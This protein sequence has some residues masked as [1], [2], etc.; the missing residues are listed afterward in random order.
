MGYIIYFYY[1][2]EDGFKH[3]FKQASWKHTFLFTY[4]TKMAAS[5]LAI[6][7]SLSAVMYTN[8]AEYKV[9]IFTISFVFVIH[10]HFMGTSRWTSL[11]GSGYHGGAQKK[12]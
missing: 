8:L 7:L 5:M 3:I 4:H 2:L 1:Q 12:S 9:N 6:A 10:E 11:T